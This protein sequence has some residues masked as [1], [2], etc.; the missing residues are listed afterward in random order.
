MLK[1][2]N[3]WMHI[4]HLGLILFFLV[5]WIFPSLRGAHLHFE[6]PIW[7]SAR[8]SFFR[9]LELG[10]L[11]ANLVFASQQ[12]SNITYEENCASSRNGRATSPI[13]AK[14]SLANL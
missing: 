8:S 7:L 11:S 13:F 6:A 3:I 14:R 10:Y 12:R 5:G 9:G 4:F 2:L 1:F